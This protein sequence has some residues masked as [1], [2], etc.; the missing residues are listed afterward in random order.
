QAGNTDLLALNTLDKSAGLAENLHLMLGL[1]QTF[2]IVDHACVTT[3]GLDDLAES[4]QRGPIS[5]KLMGLLPSLFAAGGALRQKQ[6]PGGKLHAEVAQI[7][8]TST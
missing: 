5:D 2:G 6:H 4:F 7:G 1:G 3:L 8:R